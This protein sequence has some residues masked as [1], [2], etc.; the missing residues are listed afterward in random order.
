[1]ALYEDAQLRAPTK[2]GLIREHDDAAS[3]N[4][5]VD[6]GY[7]LDELRREARR[8]QEAAYKLARTSDEQATRVYELAR[9]AYWLTIASL[10]VATVAVAA[11]VA[12]SAI[13]VSN[14]LAHSNT[15]E[16]AGAATAGAPNRTSLFEV[17]KC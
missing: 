7:H 9:Q 1:M 17:P 8:A 14:P 15:C 2:E 13:F 3:P 12:V 10:V 11:V 5:A 4:V 6:V 16:P